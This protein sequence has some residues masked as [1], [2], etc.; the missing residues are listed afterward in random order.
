MRR[1]LVG[2]VMLVG[3]AMASPVHASIVF[4]NAQPEGSWSLDTQVGGFDFDKVEVARVTPANNLEI[5]YLDDFEF[6]ADITG[7][8]YADLS[9]NVEPSAGL[10]FAAASDDLIDGVKVER[11]LPEPSTL[12]VWSCL[13][14][15]SMGL[16]VW[17][18]RRG[19]L[20]QTADRV[21]NV[22]WSDDTREAVRAIIN[23]GRIG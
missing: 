12:I 6:V 18:R 3:A 5:P 7:P 23:R 17:R 13:A 8:Y 15:G 19:P 21:G 1:W 22:A 10:E 4:L 20:G 14:L 11:V 16:N 9:W 2:L